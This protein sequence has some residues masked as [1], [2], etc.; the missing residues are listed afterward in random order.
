[1]PGSNTVE[2]S[3]ALAHRVDCSVNATYELWAMLDPAQTG[4]VTDRG[5]PSSA[6]TL[7]DIAAEPLAEDG[8]TRIHV[9]MAEDAERGR[10]QAAPARS[11]P[12]S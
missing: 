4:I 2:I 11:S 5:S 6:R 3:V 1:M 12:P 10:D 8:T 9:R 7:D